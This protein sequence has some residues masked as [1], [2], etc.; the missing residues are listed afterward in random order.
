[1]TT[2]LYVMIYYSLRDLIIQVQLVSK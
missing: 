1:M 2:S